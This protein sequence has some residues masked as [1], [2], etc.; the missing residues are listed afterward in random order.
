MPDRREVLTAGA[1]AAASWIWSPLTR[2]A[3]EGGSS[4]TGS[5]AHAAN[6]YPLKLTRGDRLLLA[7]QVNGHDVE[8]LLDSAAEASFLDR[9]FA[10][11][12]GLAGQESATAKG[13]G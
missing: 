10:Q 3:S 6:V 12:I 8:A 11:R 5:P 2:A 9:A 13:S 4:A 7:A 1:L